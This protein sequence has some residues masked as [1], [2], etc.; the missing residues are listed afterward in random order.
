MAYT[1]TMQISTSR[2]LLAIIIQNN[3]M[4]QTSNHYFIRQSLVNV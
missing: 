3:V 4:P 1:Q 2:V